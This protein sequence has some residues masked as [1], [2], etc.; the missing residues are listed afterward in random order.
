VTNI[1]NREG[2]CCVGEIGYAGRGDS[3]KA[4]LNISF[5]SPPPIL[6]D[7]GYG[8]T[9]MRLRELNQDASDPATQLT[10]PIGDTPPATGA[11]HLSFFQVG[12]AAQVV[13]SGAFG[14]PPDL[15]DLAIAPAPTERRRS[16]LE[17]ARS[18]KKCEDAGWWG[19][20][21]PKRPIW[22]LRGLADQEGPGTEHDFSIRFLREGSRDP[23]ANWKIQIDT[24]RLLSDFWKVRA[25]CSIL[26]RVVPLRGEERVETL[27]VIGGSTYFELK[28][29]RATDIYLDFTFGDRSVDGSASRIAD[30]VVMNDGLRAFPIGRNG[31]YEAFFYRGGELINVEAGA[32][33]PIATFD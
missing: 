25:G 2:F 14:A 15:N 18:E 31:V 1:I 5:S 20:H 26:G 24:A 19:G 13:E 7:F 6:V 4:F 3:R 23:D 16:I 12:K 22:D 32:L 30:P 17:V 9:S 29:G 28:W 8:D 11:Y 33:P 27:G 21:G 10:I